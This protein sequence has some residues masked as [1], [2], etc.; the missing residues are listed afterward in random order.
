MLDMQ[1]RP[2]K[3]ARTHIRWMIR[4]D[5]PEVLEIEGRAFEFPWSE[6]DF[7]G[8]LRNNKNIGQVA[9]VGQVV[10]GY[11]IYK[12]EKNKL[13]LLN[14][15]VHPDFRREGIGAAMVR[16]LTT[17]LSSHRRNRLV[18]HVCERNLDAQLFFRKQEF[19]AVRVER[20]YFQDG[21]YRE[22]AYVMV[23]RCVGEEA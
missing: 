18:V 23:Y 17:K 20:D 14:L 12:L 10:A 6:E 1:E 21:E 19:S 15:A 11:M 5:M 3:A 16:K 4:R 9:E 22:D 2:K 8:V 7:L 13:E